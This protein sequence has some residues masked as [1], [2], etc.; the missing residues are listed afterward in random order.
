MAEFLSDEPSQSKEISSDLSEV[1]GIKIENGILRVDSRE[2]DEC[3]RLANENPQVADKVKAEMNRING[4]EYVKWI[5][6][7]RRQRGLF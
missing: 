7:D 4:E 1:F 6:R 5:N 2:G 3:P